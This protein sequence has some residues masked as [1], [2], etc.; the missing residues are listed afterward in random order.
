MNIIIAGMT[1]SGKTTLS[2]SIKEKFPNSTIICEDDYMKDRVNI[3][4]R[5]NYYLM[6][7]PSAYHLDEFSS[8]A[9]KLLAEG[10]ILYPKYDVA[11]NRRLSKKEVKTKSQFNIFEGL[12]AIDALKDLRDSLKIFIDTPPSTCLE[13]RI[14]R[15]KSLYGTNEDE[16]KKYFEEVIMS[17]YKTHIQEQRYQA[18]VIIEKEGDAKCLLKKLR[19][20]Y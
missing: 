1:C 12:H 16:I 15:D 4:V 17:I 19:T 13:R 6:D 8:D 3:P 7:L 5:R 10:S 11:N 18:D 20:F 14:R 9:K 2:M